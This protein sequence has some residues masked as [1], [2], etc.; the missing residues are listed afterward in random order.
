MR[1]IAAIALILAATIA[2]AEE[3]STACH[4]LA[5]PTLE[6][7]HVPAYSVRQLLHLL[8]ERA[9]WNMPVPVTIACTETWITEEEL[10]LLV[11]L[12]DSTEPCASVTSVY[13]SS[14]RFGESSTI[15]REAALLIDGY[16]R[17]VYGDGQ[18]YGSTKDEL[19]TWWNERKARQ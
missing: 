13:S 7:D 18:R 10:E 12:L 17:G 16:R 14:L 11:G 15:G 4:P 19:K 1:V 8:R 5:R 9:E 2:S 6:A 3:P